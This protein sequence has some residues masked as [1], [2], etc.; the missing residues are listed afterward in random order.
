MKKFLALT[1]LTFVVKCL[2]AQYVTIPD[3]NFRNFL[4]NTYPYYYAMNAFDQLDTTNTYIVNSSYLNLTNWNGQ[5]YGVADITGIRYFK[6]LTNF[7]CSNNPIQALD[8]LPNT[9]TTLVAENI[10]LTGNGKSVTLPQNVVSVLLTNSGFTGFTNSPNTIISLSVKNNG[11]SILPILSSNLEF[12]DCS[13]NNLA[14]L[15][16]LPNSLKVLMCSQNILTSLACFSSNTIITTIFCDSN[17]ITTLSSLPQTVAALNCSHNNL[18]SLPF[19]QNLNMLICSFNSLSSLPTLSN[20]LAILLCDN[21]TLTSLPTLPTTLAE[22]NC[23][24]NNIATLPTLPASLE[25]LNCSHNQLTSLSN[26]PNNLF[27]FNCSFN[28]ITSIS[29]F[30]N[31]QYQSTIL[32]N[33]NQLTSLPAI[34]GNIQ[35]SFDC[36]NNQ[37]TSFPTLNNA[38]VPYFNCSNNQITSIPS[39]SGLFFIYLNCSNNLI[40]SVGDLSDVGINLLYLNNNSNIK[41]LS[42]LSNNIQRIDISNTAITCLPYI[43]SKTQVISNLT[44]GICNTQNNA[45]NC[46][47]VN[48]YVTIPDPNFRARLIQ[49]YPACFNA[50]QEMDTICSGIITYIDCS[51]LNIQTLSGVQ[52]LK[53]LHSFWCDNNNIS[54]VDSLPVNLY[55]LSCNNNQIAKINHLPANLTVIGCRN[56]VISN[57][58]S[59]PTG[60]QEIYCD[61]NNISSI[62]KLPLNLQTI[63]CNNNNISNIDSL[64]TNMKKL[65]CNNNKITSIDKLSDSISE[66]H[67]SSNLIATINKLPKNLTDFDCSFNSLNNLPRIDSNVINLNCS[68][69]NISNLNIDSNN[70]ASLNNWRWGKSLDISYN[71]FNSL[72]NL[73]TNYLSINCRN[74]HIATAILTKFKLLNFIA[75]SNNIN[76]FEFPNRGGWYDSINLIS[77]THND[78]YCLPKIPRGLN[79]LYIDSGKITCIPNIPN[80]WWFKLYS[81]TNTPLTLP[82]CNPT[83]NVNQC[84][85]FPT[86]T[87][88]V[89]LDLN[90]NNIKDAN[91]NY[92]VWSSINSGEANNLG[93]TN[94]I[95]TNNN[96]HYIYSYD[97]T[98]KYTVKYGD[99]YNYWWYSNLL[100]FAVPDSIDVHF[101]RYDTTAVLQDIALQPT[102]TV[103]SMSVYIMPNWR[104]RI[105]Q[106]FGYWV[107]Y[108]NTGTTTLNPT[109]TL[110]F[111]DTRLVYDSSSNHNVVVIGNTITLN[112]QNLQPYSNW[113]FNGFYLYF[114][115]KTTA[116]LGD[117][118]ITKAAVNYANITDSVHVDGRTIRNSYDPNEKDATPTLTPTQVANGTPIAYTVHFQNTGNDTAYNVVIA[119]TLS[120]LLQANTLQIVAASHNVKTTIRNGIVYFE[121]LNIMLPDSGVNQIKSN[122]FVTFIVKP[123]PTLVAGTNVYNKAHIYFDYNSPIITNNAVTQITNI[124]IVPLKFIN[125]T[126][127][128]NSETVVENKWITANESNVANYKVQRSIDGKNFETI[129]TQ[130][131]NNT[132][133]NTYQFNDVLTSNV[134]KVA[135]IYYR[136]IA[137]DENGFKQMSSIQVVRLNKNTTVTISPNPASS[138]IVVQGKNIAAIEFYDNM[139]KKVMSKFI[140]TSLSSIDVSTLTKGIYYVKILLTDGNFETQKLI[141][142]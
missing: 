18:T 115:V 24:N 135:T 11:L 125:Y 117:S 22:L 49:Y 137:T 93:D 113:W 31:R 87:G 38:N 134:Q 56:N 53:N 10:A 140:A 17:S 14:N 85:G 76:H 98:G 96:G 27:D 9:I 141:V 92:M 66:L 83:N 26:I 123:L 100:L 133:S 55:S 52:Y 62:S 16:L 142:Q 97:D 32:V 21:N 61:N 60:L 106:P 84:L 12:L 41:C 3:A 43:P 69:N 90:K 131:A 101:S 112:V 89:Y 72:P 13:N 20:N 58:D 28:Q 129:A 67:C 91:E 82:V 25:K 34:Q 68:H 7:N 139:G 127:Q 48:P 119:D 50:N 64:P 78:L 121:F 109:I 2:T 19:L 74:N 79:N 35:I 4:K 65:Y 8:N 51:S 110:Q 44:I 54:N 128:L 124:T 47:I 5:G 70:T 33:N 86:I 1:A 130:K 104:A 111:D 80:S 99:N 42:I 37:L 71:R 95:Y 40:S 23:S 30:S 107:N 138:H 59:L 120:N 81:Q 114:H 122:G 105:G 94:R 6:N 45:N 77:L 75:D 116:V 46:A 118:L 29:N 63:Y 136:I 36:S 73:G 57:I 126:A 103:D 102:H 39:L 88:N 132:V 108:M 15:P